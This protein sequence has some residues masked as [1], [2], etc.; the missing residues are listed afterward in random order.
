MP[1]GPGATATAA[2]LVPAVQDSLHALFQIAARVNP[3]F[4]GA[5]V[6]VVWASGW[7][8][9]TDA[10]AIE[11]IERA[12]GE[13]VVV[14]PS[15]QRQ[16]EPGFPCVYRWGQTYF[17]AGVTPGPEEGETL[18]FFY[19]RQPAALSAPTD[20]I[21]S[22]YP[23]S[24]RTLLELDTAIRLAIKDGGATTEILEALGGE[25]HDALSRYVAHLEHETIGER[26]THGHIR[27]FNTATLVPVHS[28]LAGGG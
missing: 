26:R 20:S 9:P 5:S 4:Y 17:P 2:E 13:N 19:S 24:H 21:D 15:D 8:R 14:V 22:A 10:E 16:A 3:A 25:R 1:D 11:R 7:P 28:M 23:T 6:A 12:D 18:T 27:K